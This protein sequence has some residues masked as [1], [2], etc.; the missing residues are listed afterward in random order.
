MMLVLTATGLVVGVVVT[1][2]VH[3]DRAIR[4]VEDLLRKK[5]AEVMQVARL[6]LVERNGVG[7]RAR[8]QPADDGRA[9]AGTLRAAPRADA[10]RRSRAR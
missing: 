1:E 7:A 6:N 8:D 2:R 9:R 4:A 10:E 5:E 3:A